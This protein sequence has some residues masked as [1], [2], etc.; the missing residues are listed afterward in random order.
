M[1]TFLVVAST[2]IVFVISAAA[3]ATQFLSIV[4][5]L[6]PIILQASFNGANLKAWMKYVHVFCLSAVCLGSFYGKW[7]S[8][9]I[10]EGFNPFI[11]GTGEGMH[12]KLHLH[13]HT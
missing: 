3:A 13:R 1:V 12:I 4:F 7:S 2:T 10:I 5:L 9:K 8:L 11:T 6:L